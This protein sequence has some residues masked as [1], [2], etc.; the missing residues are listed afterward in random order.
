M[1]AII[2]AAGLGTRLKPFTD[3]CPKAL[4][5]LNGKPLLWYAI[6]NLEKFGVNEI[7]VNIHHF[8]EQIIH[9]IQMT[10]FEAD[11]RISDERYAL[12]D[13]GGGLLKAKDFFSG[14]EPVLAC[15]V[16]V[17]SSVNLADVVAYHLRKGALATL[18]VR[19][20]ETS[21]YFMFDKEMQLTGWKNCTSGEEIVSS[22][23]YSHSTPWAFSG[24][25]VL[26]PEIFSYISETGKFSI[27]PMYLRLAQ[28]HKII[29]YPDLSNFWMDL[30]KPEQ[31]AQAEK[32]LFG[33]K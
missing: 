28:S 12:L 31:L 26:S 27:T 9:F 30:G 21:R 23:G 14:N 24:I 6:R 5:P 3:N 13:T 2:F 15:N 8:G 1:K 18:V 17:V 4:V 7:V 20:R 33:E 32:Y 10:K 16:D 25:Q 19:Q 11:I 29:G 22:H